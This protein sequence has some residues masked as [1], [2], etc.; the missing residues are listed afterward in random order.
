MSDAIRGAR[1]SRYRGRMPER[2]RARWQQTP[3]MVKVAV[4]ALVIN[5]MALPL[6]IGV[7]YVLDLSRCPAP[8]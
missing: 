2:M 1:M 4:G 8:G 5:A 6:F 3:T 7:G